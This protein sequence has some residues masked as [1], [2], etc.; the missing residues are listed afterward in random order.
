[1]QQR[2]DSRRAVGGD[3][4]CDLGGC[5]ARGEQRCLE[6]GVGGLLARRRDKPDRMLGGDV[7]R[8]LKPP[9]R[10]LGA[11]VVEH[12]GLGRC[13]IEAR[14]RAHETRPELT[15]LLGVEVVGAGPSR[16]DLMLVVSIGSVKR[17]LSALVVDDD[18]AI[19]VLV[20][21]NLELEGFA[22][23]EAA[24]L[25]EA[26]AAVQRD[27]PAVVLLDVHLGTE[28][29]TELLAELRADGIPV[30]VV[31]GSADIEDYEDAADGVL[32]K[33]FEPDTLIALAHRLAR[34]EA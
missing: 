22:V 14:K 20:R 28:D 15:E 25:A 18:A 2:L 30:A 4:L 11:F 8:V 7:K 27:R 29:T 6:L 19:R 1:M 5:V 3:G 10:L 34:V 23:S 24:T 9:E 31:T 26:A 32:A 17:G 12:V 33:P 13:E 16:H 21:I